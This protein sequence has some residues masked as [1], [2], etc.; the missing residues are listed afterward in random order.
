VY[1]ELT[2]ASDNLFLGDAA[3]TNRIMKTNDNSGL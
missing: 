2:E 1:R 3:M